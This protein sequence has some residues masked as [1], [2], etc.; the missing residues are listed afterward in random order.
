M[1]YSALFSSWPALLLGNQC[2]ESPGNISFEYTNNYTTG[3]KNKQA[4]F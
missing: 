3:Y 4:T 2:C 1:I